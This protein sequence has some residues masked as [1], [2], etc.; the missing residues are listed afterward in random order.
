M[1]GDFFFF[2]DC[3]DSGDV[4]KREANHAA[5]SPMIISTAKLPG[6]KYQ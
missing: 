2:F 5:K 3:H 6:P 1:S 4:W